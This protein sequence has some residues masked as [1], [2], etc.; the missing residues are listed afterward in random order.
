MQIEGEKH[1][2]QPIE[3]YGIIGDLNTIALVGLDGS[4][5]FMCFPNFDSPSVFA[6][7]LDA[8]RG[9][10]FQIEPV[11]K[12]K[13]NRQLYLPDTNVLLTTIPFRRRSGRNYRFYACGGA[14]LRERTH[15]ARHYREGRGV[16]R[17]EM[18]PPF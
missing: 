6:S 2:Y 16:L 10:K 14:V 13:K 4:I 17:D 8:D 5:D 12:R 7:L 3:N 9:G 11:F 15:K 1:R 18:P